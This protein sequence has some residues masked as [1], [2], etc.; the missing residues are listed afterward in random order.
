MY[1]CVRSMKLS[2]QEVLLVSFVFDSYHAAEET[3]W[4]YTGVYI[5]YHINLSNTGVYITYHINLSRCTS[6][7]VGLPFM[8]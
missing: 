4:G 8:F 2:I 7:T 6:L 1:L 3:L 5:T